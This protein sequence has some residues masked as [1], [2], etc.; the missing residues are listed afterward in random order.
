MRDKDQTCLCIILKGFFDS[1][2]ETM[3]IEKRAELKK[4]VW[5]TKEK[6]TTKKS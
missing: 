4:K 2:K 5:A 3:I 1:N 6:V